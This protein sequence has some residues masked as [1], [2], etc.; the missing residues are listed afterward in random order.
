MRGTVVYKMSGSG[1]D[2]VMVDGRTSPVSVWTPERVREVCARHTGVGADGL[3]VLE[4]GSPD[5]VRFHY[6]NADGNRTAMCGNASLCAARLAS[7]LELAPDDMILETD[8]GPIPARIL[9]GPGE[10][11]EIAFPSISDLSVPDIETAAGERSI[12]FVT[13]GVPHLVVVVDEV[14]G[15]PATL[16][17]SRGRDLRSHPVLGEAGANVNFL[18]CKDGRWRMRTYERGVEA[19]TLSCGTGA[20]AAA[21]TLASA[22]LVTLPWEVTTTAGSTLQIS[23]E[24][25]ENATVLENPR[26]A[27]EAR[28]VFRAVLL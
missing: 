1:N 3:A 9:P 27:G 6:F 24:T 17:E 5:R 15:L 23:G 12:H 8:I 19:E 22:G 13:V 7:R 28:M 11:A 16:L 26:L 2:F 18:G 4:P 21:A 20:V 10:R 25:A 14:D